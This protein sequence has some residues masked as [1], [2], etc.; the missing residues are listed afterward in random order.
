MI[1][2]FAFHLSLIVHISGT[3]IYLCLLYVEC[4]T[5]ALYD[6]QAEGLFPISFFAISFFSEPLNVYDRSRRDEKKNVDTFVHYT[7][8]ARR[9][10]TKLKN[11][12]KDE[13]ICM[14]TYPASRLFS[15]QMLGIYF[16]LLWR[17]TQTFHCIFNDFS[18]L[19][20]LLLL[21]K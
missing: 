3:Y 13:I 11:K 4:G 10:K 19:F 21:R 15:I 20:L 17:H 5:I 9:E 14:H 8:A 7:H 6:C 12:A 16:T 18:Y 2:A 1:F